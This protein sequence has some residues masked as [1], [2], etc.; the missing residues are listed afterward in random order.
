MSDFNINITGGQSKRLLTGGKYVPADILIRPEN[1]D[2]EISVQ[3][4]LLTQIQNALA[5][6]A[7]T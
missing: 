5:A 3:D 2:E 4:N 7:N 6:K 1:L